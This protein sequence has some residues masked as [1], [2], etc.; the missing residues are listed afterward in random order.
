MYEY[1]KNYTEERDYVEAGG[2]MS[3]LTVTITLCEYRE[4]IRNAAMQTAEIARLNDEN[5]NYKEL[6]D[7][8]M[9]REERDEDR[10]IEERE[11]DV[12]A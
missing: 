1:V 8:M 5:R 10:M 4:L 9:L 3:E 11:A 12:N 6:L 7:M 2:S